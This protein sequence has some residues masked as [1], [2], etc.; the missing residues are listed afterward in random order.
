MGAVVCCVVA[1]T[2]EIQVQADDWSTARRDLGERG[3]WETKTIARAAV[4]LNS[5]E[6]LDVQTAQRW[7][8]QKKAASELDRFE[9]CAF[10][11]PPTEED[12]LGRARLAILELLK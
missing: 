3:T 1:W 11:F 7:C 6:P 5:A 12:P 2:D 9:C 4:W 10:M 8:D